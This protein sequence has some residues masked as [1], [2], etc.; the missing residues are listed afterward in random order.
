MATKWASL[1]LASLALIASGMTACYMEVREE[2]DDAPGTDR[3]T[4]PVQ[5]RGDSR[6]CDEGER[7]AR[8]GEGDTKGGQCFKNDDFTWRTSCKSSAC[9]SVKVFTHYMLTEDL[10]NGHPVHVEAFDNPYFQG[11]PRASVRLANFEAK[12]GTWEEAELYLEPGEYYLMAYMSTDE[13]D[14]V[15][16][17]AVRGMTLVQDVPVGIYGAVS[18]AELVR[19]A[20]RAQNRYPAPVHIYLDRQFKEPGSEPDTKAHLRLML[21]VAEDAAGDDITTLVPD[22]RDVKIRLHAS[23][24]LSVAPVREFAMASALLLVQGRVGR[25]EYLTPSLPVG[26]YVVF[27]YVDANGSG[28]YEDGELSAVHKV[29]HLVTAVRVVKDRTESLSLVLAAEPAL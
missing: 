2:G 15:R 20:P 29:N 4:D 12:P 18:S 28:F 22:G 23:Q 24:D 19:V 26:D 5:L 11:S 25:T 3:V 9:Q 16:P 27:V 7:P 17:Y 13:K 10:G 6:A 1:K 8:F 14:V 21:Q